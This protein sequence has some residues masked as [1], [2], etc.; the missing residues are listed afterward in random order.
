MKGKNIS[1]H[2]NS[3][4]KVRYQVS[5]ALFSFRIQPGIILQEFLDQILSWKNWE[6]QYMPEG[7]ITGERL[8]LGP[9][10]TLRVYSCYIDEFCGVIALVY[11]GNKEPLSVI[12][13]SMTI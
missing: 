6:G 4:Y 8:G 2:S 10:V 5:N 1:N 9:E 3:P 12:D 11:P 7:L 13:T